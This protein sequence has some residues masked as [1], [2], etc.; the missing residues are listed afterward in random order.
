MKV[1][2]INNNQLQF[3]ANLPKKELTT[4]VDS[5]LCH[6]KTAGIPKLYTLLEQLDKMPGDKAKLTT[7][8]KNSQSDV[9]GLAAGFF[10]PNSCQL[11]IDDELVAEGQNIFDTLYSYVTS[12]QTK[13]GKKIQMPQTIFDALWWNNAEKN[14]SDVESLLKD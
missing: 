4:L 9:V 13:D 2:P 5:A 14:V 11:R 8:I 6:D 12:K 7:I 3:R 10:K 1:T